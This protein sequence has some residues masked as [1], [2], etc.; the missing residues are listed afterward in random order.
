MLFGILAALHTGHVAVEL[1][2]HIGA[3]D[4][5]GK[6]RQRIDDGDTQLARLNGIIFEI[7]HGVQALDD[8]RA[9]GL[10]AQAALLHLLHE[11]ALA[12]ARGRLGLLGL[13]LN[14]EYVDRIALLKRRHLLV[15]FKAI[16]VG[17]AETRGH[18]HIARSH[19][20][21]TVH[22]ELELG[23]LDGRGTHERR[24]EAAGDEVVELALAAVER[25]RI[26]LAR[27]ID[28]RVVG[29]LD[30]A[31]RRLHGAGKHLFAYGRQRRVDLCQVAH[32][33]AQIERRGVHGI[34]DTRV[35]DETGHVEGLSDAHGT[36]RRDALGRGGSLQRGGRKRRGRLLLA[37]A[38]GHRGDGCR[39]DAVN[40]AVR[41]LSSILVGKARRLVRDLKAIVLGSALRG[42]HA[43][44]LPI[45]LG[46]KRHALALALD[47][48]GKRRRLHAAGGA[49]VTKAA[50]LG[51]R[52]V[53]R[54]HRT[55][56]EVDVLT[57]LACVGQ[58]LVERDEII[59]GLRDLGLGK[60]RI[61]GAGNRQVRRHLA[62]LVE[63]VRTDQLALAVE[64][65]SD[66]DAVGLLGKVL[67]RA[68]E[69]FLG[70]QLNDGCPGE[71][72][73]TLELPAL[74][75][76]AI[77]KERLTLG[78]VRR[79]SQAIGHVG[80]QHLAVLGD[81][82]P[83]QL[84]IEQHAVAKIGRKDVTGKT[85]RHALLA[86]PL[87]T[88]DGGVVHLV[89]FR[90]TRGQPLGDLT[91]GVVF[92]GDDELQ[93]RLLSRI[94]TATP[95]RMAADLRPCLL[96]LPDE[97]IAPGV[98]ALA[99]AR[100]HGKPR[101]LRIEV[102][103]CLSIPIHV[104]IESRGHVDLIEQLRASVLEDARVLDGLV[105]ALGHRED[106]DGQVLAQVKVD[107]ADQVTHVF[108]KDD[109]DVFQTHSLVKRVNGL[110]D[111]VALEV[112]QAARVDLDGGHAGFLHGN[113]IDIRGDVALDDGAAQAGLV[114]QVLVG[115]QN[116]SGLARA[117]A[118]QHI[119][120]I[121]ACLIKSLS[122]LICQALIARQNRR[123]DINRFLS[124]T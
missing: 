63:G 124:H 109:V 35:A 64:V 106:H 83:A 44:N 71:I 46:H 118:R 84:F 123:R 4:A 93:K 58:V 108:D 36:R 57:A 21:L 24:Q 76:D 25:G 116:R 14:V 62:H 8:A 103:E 94:S 13:E 10:G 33:G 104:K 91:R 67:E 113:G 18:E 92:L 107:W 110:H 88:V 98:H 39:R 2:G 122:Q 102:I 72:G 73:Q 27:G 48:Q 53:A 119:D 112:A 117:R 59:E 75:G 34:V 66:D 121:G 69:L 37:R 115:A 65:R 54:Q 31:A 41:R 101:R 105:V 49:H 68:N 51:E 79:T 3:R 70:R 43:A 61:L 82:I 29:G 80:R 47:H 19:E 87:K 97:P 17:L 32:H 56:N 7:A 81:R 50:K 95:A 74:D 16:R 1:A 55:P 28:R 9:R 60:R 89:L 30:F 85:D 99:L 40:M 52:Q 22:I 77:G 86:L 96:D 114:A 111:H 23:V 12:V 26:A 6:L 78:V 90:L 45:V 38:L 120:H 100:A 11:L 42:T 20:R 5:R 15:A